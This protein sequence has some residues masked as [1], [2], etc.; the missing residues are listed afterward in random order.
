MNTDQRGLLSALVGDGRALITFSGLCLGLA[1]VFAIFQSMTGHFLPHDIEFLN[2]RPE[3]LCGINECRIVHFMIHDRIS[4]GGALVAIAVLYLWIAAFPMRNGEM[5][6]W[7]TIAGSGVSGFGSFL[8]YL[9]YGY[10]DTWHGAATLVLLPCFVAGLWMLRPKRVTFSD[11]FLTSALIPVS[12]FSLRGS[13]GIGRWCVLLS[14]AGMIGAGA[15]IQVIGMTSVFV[16]TDLEFMGIDREQLNAINPRLIPLIAH[17]RAG[18]GGAVAT[19]GLLTVAC[20]WF[21]R[22]SRSLWQALSVGGF[23]GWSTSV[24]VHPAIGYT[25][26]WHLAPAVGGAALFLI[27][28]FLL[29]P[30]MVSRKGEERSPSS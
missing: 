21:G 22:P 14:A 11:G 9:G 24:F 30:E 20:L 23:V 28:L 16:P 15:T 7:W 26:A 27:G 17:D 19:A 10:L 6:A 2:M 29:R 8:T 1:G 4:F 3:E 12:N 18:F 5:W 25:D 13:A